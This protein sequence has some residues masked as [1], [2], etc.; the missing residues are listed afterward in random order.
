MEHTTW[1]SIKNWAETRFQITPS[2]R[3]SGDHYKGQIIRKTT[4]LEEMEQSLFTSFEDT[5]AL[6][7][8]WVWPFFLL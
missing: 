2:D 6:E 7:E 8:K 5:T 1:K 4:V 3:Y